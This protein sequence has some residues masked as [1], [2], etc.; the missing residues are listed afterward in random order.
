M[1]LVSA[2]WRLACPVLAHVRCVDGNVAVANVLVHRTDRGHDG[3]M[4]RSLDEIAD[5]LFSLHDTLTDL[6]VEKANEEAALLAYGWYARVWHT[7]R[8]ALVLHAQGFI[9][10]AAPLRRSL[11]EH[12]LS[13]QWIGHSP[14]P[15]YDA[16]AEKHQFEVEKFGDK[17][18]EQSTIS[19]DVIDE[20]LA[21]QLGR[22]PESHLTHIYD[23]CKMY[24]PE[25][26]YTAWFHETGQ[27]HASWSS[28]T[29]YKTG[30]PTLDYSM[31][32]MVVVWLIL[33]TSGFSMILLGDPWAE[34][35]G[36]IDRELGELR[37]RSL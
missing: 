27:S 9:T 22:S 29:P 19:R 25:G 26:S 11:L 12:A 23:L 17:L 7:A 36:R 30:R 31:D 2:G 35:A 5:E 32:T 6:V 14:G 16:I 24:G 10:E 8:A 34:V 15:A 1:C 3:S 37:S 28:A 13:L 4:P 33:A 20:L 18:D 21:V